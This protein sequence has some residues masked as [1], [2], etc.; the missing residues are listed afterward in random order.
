MNSYS[1]KDY[2]IPNDEHL[3]C[4]PSKSYTDKSCFTFE[5]LVK[6]AKA[7]NNHSESNNLTPIQTENVSK[8]YLVDSLSNVITNCKSKS[9]LCWLEQ[10]WIK[11][12]VDNDIHKNTFR[13]L[14]PQGRF[15]WLSTTNINDIM[16]QYENKYLDFK[17]LGAVPYDFYELPQLGIRTLNFDKL[18]EKTKRFGMVINLDEHYKRGSHWV[19]LYADLSKNQVYY[20]D[21]Y[22]IKP[23]NRICEYVKKIV[24]WLYNRKILNI[25]PMQKLSEQKN[26]EQKMS[27][28]KI[29]EEIS[30]NFDTESKFMGRTK[31]KYEQ[32]KSFDIAYNKIRH[33]F[34]NSEC[35]VYSVNFILRLLN[36]KTFNEIC[37]NPT[38]DDKINECRDVY[39]RF[40]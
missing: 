34:K 2:F 37:L 15:K 26:S 1:N 8:Q 20:F 10:S 28:Q 38:S 4:A 18:Y 3:K 27:E 33:Q 22:G 23:K 30:L 25:D 21:S 24:G 5:A 32:I 9:Q 16:I 36:G 13:P 6:M 29:S 17:F 14:G 11:Q 35:G 31:N 12:I 19:S 39:F 40:E 7:Y